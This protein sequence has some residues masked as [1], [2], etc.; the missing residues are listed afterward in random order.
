MHRIRTLSLELKVIKLHTV[1]PTDYLV[2]TLAT[3]FVLSL[4]LWD[5]SLTHIMNVSVTLP[6][7]RLTHKHKDAKSFENYLNPAI[8]VFIG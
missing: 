8:S 5:G 1:S 2:L 4:S 6:M 7:R 3:C